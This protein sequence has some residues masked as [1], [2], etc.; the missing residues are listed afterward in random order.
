MRLFILSIFICMQYVNAQD[1]DYKNNPEYHAYNF[2]NI[3]SYEQII[4]AR[5]Q[6]VQKNPNLKIIAAHLASMANN[7]SPKLSYPIVSSF[8]ENPDS[9]KYLQTLTYKSAMVFSMLE[10]LLGD[11]AFQKGLQQFFNNNQQEENLGL[12]KTLP[13]LSAFEYSLILVTLLLNSVV[14]IFSSISYSGSM[15]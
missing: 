2:P 3:P 9:Q 13:L 8:R 4:Q 1:C 15:P 6:W 14:L 5:D 11:I 10:Y 12:V 7:I